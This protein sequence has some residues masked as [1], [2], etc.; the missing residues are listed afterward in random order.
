[1]P[2]KVKD[3]VLCLLIIE[4]VIFT[5]PKF[6]GKASVFSDFQKGFSFFKNSVFIGGSLNQ[7]RVRSYD[8]E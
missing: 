6:V 5:M 3:L 2:C 7:F 8:T 1:M 4:T